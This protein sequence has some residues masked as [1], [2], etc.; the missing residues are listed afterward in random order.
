MPI[1]NWGF[2]LNFIHIF[3]KSVCETYLPFKCQ[4]KV[5]LQRA[6]WTKSKKL[7]L[8]SR[9]DSVNETHFHF[10]SFVERSKL[11]IVIF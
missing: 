6:N 2:E 1:V 3:I 5:N 4:N 8:L 10:E 9:N 7:A 11:I